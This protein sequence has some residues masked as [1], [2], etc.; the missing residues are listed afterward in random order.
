MGVEGTRL[1]MWG[2]STAEITFAGE[3]FRFP[4]LVSSSLTTDAILDMDFLEDNNCTLEMCNKLLHFPDRGVSISL[5]DSPSEP[6][7]VQARV[8]LEETLTIPPFSEIEVMAKV[9]RELYRGT[10]LLEECR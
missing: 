6:H 1:E 4:V 2:T 7:I 5:R 8:T 10:W 3:T 9:S